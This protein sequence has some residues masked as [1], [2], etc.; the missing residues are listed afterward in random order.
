MPKPVERSVPMLLNQSAPC[1][2]IGGTEAIDSTLLTT[3]GRA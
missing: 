1:S 3:V 2:R